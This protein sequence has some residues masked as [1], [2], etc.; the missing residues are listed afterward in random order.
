MIMTDQD[1]RA[2]KKATNEFVEKRDYNYRKSRLEVSFRIPNEDSS[3]SSVLS[4]HRYR[5]GSAI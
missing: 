1:K 2:I 4:I 5:N 3:G